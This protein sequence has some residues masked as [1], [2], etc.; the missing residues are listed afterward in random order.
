M[1]IANSV[2]KDSF[3]AYAPSFC[4]DEPRK[5]RFYA[6]ELAIEPSYFFFGRR[7]KTSGAQIKDSQVRFMPSNEAPRLLE[8]F[9]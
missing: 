3:T 4:G 7:A 5:G 9:L 1:L 6:P 2:P 8:S